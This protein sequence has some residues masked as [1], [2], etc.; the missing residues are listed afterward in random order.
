MLI[1]M[2]LVFLVLLISLLLQGALGLKS[3]EECESIMSISKAMG[4]YH[5]AAVSY[6]YLDKSASA[7][8]TCL[9]IWNTYG[10]P[11]GYSDDY[12]NRAEL[13]TNN[14]LFDVARITGNESSC[15]YITQRESSTGLLGTSTNVQMCVQQAE[16][17]R[18]LRPANFFETEEYRN[19][20]CAISYVLPLFA[21]A[22]FYYSTRKTYS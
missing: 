11:G 18:K 17:T 22:A 2:R 14:C 5:T 3:P 19:S 13:E 20:I 7:Q 15:Y 1:E 21:L 9:L 12:A 6:A 4:C 8:G 16:N 10:E